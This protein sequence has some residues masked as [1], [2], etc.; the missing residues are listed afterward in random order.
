M[1]SRRIGPATLALLILVAGCS[2]DETQVEGVGL[3]TST[4][5][6]RTTTTTTT[7]ATT[8]TS[9]PPA[10]PTTVPPILTDGV[11]VTDDTIY[12]GLLTD[13]TGPFSGNVVDVVDGQVAFWRALNEA[14]GIA[15]R[16]VELLIADTGYDP[17]QHVARYEELK[18]RVLMFSQSVGSPQTALI[19]P[20]LVQDQ[21]LAIPATWYSGWA[22]PVLGANVLETGSNYCM[23]AMNGLSYLTSLQQTETG[24]LPT[25]AVATNPGDYGQD[26]AAGAR[27]AAAQLGLTIVYDGEGAIGGPETYGPVAAAI[28]Q[29]GANWTWITTD[30]LSMASIVG[31]ALQAGYTGRWSGAMPTFSPRLLD[32]ALG[33]YL[34]QNW[35]LSALYSPLGADVEGMSGVYAVLADAYPDRY[36]SDGMILGYLEFDVARQVLERAAAAGDL[37]PAGVLAAA[38]SIGELTFGGIGPPNTYTGAPNDY[39]SRATAI[40]R[41]DKALFDA[42]GG[43]EATFAAGARSPFTPVQGF[44][45]SGLAAGY[46]FTGPCYVLPG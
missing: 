20:L 42:E 11:T 23:E 22:D 6:P 14:G 38:K 15:G 1:K 34:S 31:S 19:A 28:A 21:R 16:R 27:Y 18:D 8:T 9:E 26:S 13:L 7:P 39:V 12:I 10:P 35:I 40:Y 41:P 5:V 44:T 46:D 45:V 24:A 33:P 43:L 3:T 32:T 25:I 37:T 30:P 4:T 2:T 17:A 36:P 29:S